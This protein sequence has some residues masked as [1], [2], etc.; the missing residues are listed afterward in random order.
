MLERLTSAIAANRFDLGARPGDLTAIGGDGRDW[1]RAQ[2]KDAAPRL[3]DPQLRSSSDI[4]AEAL[5]L[6]R[7]IRASRKGAAP[8]EDSLAPQPVAL[9]EVR[10]RPARMQSRTRQRWA[11]ESRSAVAIPPARSARR[12]EER[13]P[14]LATPKSFSSAAS[15]TGSRHHSCL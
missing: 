14:V 15:T 10:M 9:T 11:T 6:R 5:E 1:L 8:E 13:Q 4:L 3:A 7:E 12:G 2:L